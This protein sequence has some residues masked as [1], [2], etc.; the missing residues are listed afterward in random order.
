MFKVTTVNV[1]FA[2]GTVTF[3]RQKA[4]RED[5]EKSGHCELANQFGTMANILRVILSYSVIP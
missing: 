4:S 5:V 2:R 1:S 3:L